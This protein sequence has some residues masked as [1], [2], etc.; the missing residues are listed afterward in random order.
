M[1]GL[2]ELLVRRDHM[3]YDEAIEAVTAVGVPWSFE[4]ENADE[5]HNRRD[6]R[7][8]QSQLIASKVRR[9]AY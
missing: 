9:H 8:R 1:S 5:N 4:A 6:N 3:D 7:V 2:V